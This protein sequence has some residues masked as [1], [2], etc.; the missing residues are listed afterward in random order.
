MHLPGIVPLTVMPFG[1]NEELDERAQ[2]KME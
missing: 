2:K 1:A